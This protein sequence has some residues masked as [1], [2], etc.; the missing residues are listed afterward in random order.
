MSE[1]NMEKS[2]VKRI[3]LR[4]MSQ[5]VGTR[6]NQAENGTPLSRANANNCRDAVAMFVMPFAM[7]RMIIMEVIAVA[8]PLD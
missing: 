7:E 2:T 3:E 5:P 8:A 4:G 6:W 1:S